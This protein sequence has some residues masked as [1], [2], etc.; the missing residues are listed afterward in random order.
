M[1]PQRI[2]AIVRARAD[3]QCQR[4]KPGCLHVCDHTELAYPPD[5]LAIMARDPNSPDNHICV[6]TNCQS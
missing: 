4:R 5:Q 6:C 2:D 3:N 1:N